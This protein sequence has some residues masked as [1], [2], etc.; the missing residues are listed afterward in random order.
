MQAIIMAHI[1]SGAR[2]MP[3]ENSEEI[4]LELLKLKC[5]L[6]F[7][8]EPVVYTLTTSGCQVDF[9]SSTLCASLWKMRFN[10]STCCPSLNKSEVQSFGYF[11]SETNRQNSSLSRCR[12]PCIKLSACRSHS[13]I[14]ND[15]DCSAIVTYI[16]LQKRLPT[17]NQNPRT[18]MQTLSTY[19]K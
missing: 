18:W 2:N 8:S 1:K 11:S 17:E 6:G 14:C 5:R 12:F 3:N 15:G 7:Q 13:S 16:G 9:V 19:L 4:W 10:I